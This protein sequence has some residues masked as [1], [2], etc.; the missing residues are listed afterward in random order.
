METDRNKNRELELAQYAREKLP[1]RASRIGYPRHGLLQKKVLRH[2]NLA[3]RGGPLH[4]TP[5]IRRFTSIWPR[6]TWPSEESARRPPAL[7]NTL[8]LNPGDSLRE[9]AEKLLTF[10]RLRM[11]TFASG[12]RA[13]IRILVS[14]R[15]RRRPRR[16]GRK[17]SHPPL[18]HVQ[19]SRYLDK[20]LRSQGMQDIE[21]HG[22][23]DRQRGPGADF[24]NGDALRGNCR[25]HREAPAGGGYIGDEHSRQVSR[26]AGRFPVAGRVPVFVRIA[27]PGLVLSRDRTRRRPGRHGRRRQGRRPED[28]RVHSWSKDS[29]SVSPSKS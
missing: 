23:S 8:A 19:Q 5:A 26:N 13:A 29:S 14:S 11:R 20:A 16:T 25:N 24:E 6:H 7:K 22:R 17:R 1:G 27:R 3:V 10:R 4:G 15:R 28:A 12:F 18:G 21:R 2:G 9:K